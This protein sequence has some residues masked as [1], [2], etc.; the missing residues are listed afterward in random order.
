MAVE[1]REFL[2]DVGFVGEEDDLLGE[3]LIVDRDFEAGT[4]NPLVQ[5]LTMALHHGW[6]KPANFH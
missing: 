4:L 5:R 6:M 3:A 2:G 1:P